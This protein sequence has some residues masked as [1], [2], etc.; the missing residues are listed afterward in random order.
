MVALF[1]YRK[2]ILSIF[3]AVIMIFPLSVVYGGKTLVIDDANLMTED[4]ILD[5]NERANA[6]SE[7]F[8]MDIVIVTTDDAEG[9]TTREYADDYFDYNGFG[10]GPD[11]DGFI[12]LLD[13]DNR[14]AYVSATGIGI[15]YFTDERK[16]SI[17][18]M[19]FEG[20]LPE[21]DYYG[22]ALGFLEGTEYYLLRG[23]PSDQYN[24]PEE[25][26]KENKLTSTD[27]ILSLLGG[28]VVGGGFVLSTK[29]QYRFRKKGNPYSYKNNSVV[30]FNSNQD[31]LINSF[32]THRIIPK[33]KPTNTSKPTSGRSTT[34]R[35]S[36]GRTHS[37]RGRK[38]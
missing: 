11:Y 9:K 23:I 19:I 14:E 6:L 18:D 29:A 3:L 25:V 7:E 27:I 13:M 5:L 16:E 8:N 12:F 2:M 15:R 1:K 30:H 38:F 26:I 36:S 32:V 33:P 35:S 37:G 34:H 24:E 31:R 10:V 20:G 22:A 4:E 17:L 28:L 21:G